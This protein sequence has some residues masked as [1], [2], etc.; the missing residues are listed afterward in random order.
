MYSIAAS[1]LVL[2]APGEGE[3]RGGLVRLAADRRGAPH[4]V[5]LGR[6]LEE[7]H[8]VR[9]RARVDDRVGGLDALARAQA[10]HLERLGELRVD[11]GVAPEHVVDAARALD[12]L[13]QLRQE[14]AV[15]GSA[16]SAS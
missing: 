6:L 14:L 4:H 5:E 11:G 16:S 3:P 12:Q 9:D 15:S 8:R 13:G 10:Q 1:Q 7:P 2:V